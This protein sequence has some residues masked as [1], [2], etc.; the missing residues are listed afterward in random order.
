M[1]RTQR[2][3]LIV[4]LLVLPVIAQAAD[5]VRTRNVR[6]IRVMTQNLYV[7]ADIFRVLEAQ[8]P[9][10]VPFVVAGIWQTMEETNYP[11]RAASIAA[12]IDHERPDVVG[13]QEVA[14]LTRLSP[15]EPPQLDEIEFLTILLDALQDRG[16]DYSVGGVVTNSDTQLP[17]ATPTGLGLV[18]YI[19]RDVVLVRPTVEVSEV[20]AGNYLAML[21]VPIG[22][23]PV[24]VAQFKRGYVTMKLGFA[25]RSFRL[26]NT[27]LE[28]QG[29]SLD[30]M[31]PFIQAAQAQ[32]L[33]GIL[34]AETLPVIVTGDMNS[35]PLDAPAPPLVPPYWQFL[36]AGYADMWELKPGPTE[37][38]YTCCQA[39]DLLNPLS[40]LYERVDLILVRNDP[41]SSGVTLVG[42]VRVDAVGDE[43]ADLTPSGLWPS[44]HAGVAAQIHI[45]LPNG[46]GHQRG[47]PL[48]DAR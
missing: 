9:E 45:P 3:A 48:A 25:G 20:V 24:A 28:I 2:L 32:E 41:A 44:D 18:R 36:A 7:G 14:W 29:A 15:G 6:P 19:D 16:L 12:Q 8:A 5:R 47:A 26:A 40:M 42:P 38:G 11:E 21:E 43:P 31:L 13:L 1:K 23:P 22:D 17:I 35:S 27:H 33:I 30:P 10:E 46:R 4:S 39:E 34:A 37:P